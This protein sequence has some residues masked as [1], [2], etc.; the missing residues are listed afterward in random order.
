MIPFLSIIIPVYKVENYLERCVRS[1]L[2]Q[3]YQDYEIILV[4]DGSPDRCPQICDELAKEDNRITVIHKHNGG[5]SSARNAG[6]K[7]ASGDYFAFLDS[8][9]FWETG[10]L[11]YVIQRLKQGYVDM[12][13]YDTI[14]LFPDGIKRKRNNHGFFNQDYIVYDKIDYY[15]KLIEVADFM[16]SA[17]TKVVSRTFL[18]NND[19]LF[20]EGITGEDTEWM[21]RLLRC[22]DKIGVSN[23][24]LFICTYGRTGSIQN[25]IQSKNIIDLLSTIDKSIDFY[26]YNDNKIKKF[27]MEQCA[28]LLSNATGLLRYIKDKNIKTQLIKQLKQRSFLFQY[29]SN[30][31]TLMVKKVYNIFGYNILVLFLETYLYLKRKNILNR[32]KKVDE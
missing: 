14:E 9:D 23:V 24:E 7:A 20:C 22:A 16:E 26:K 10:K 18:Q 11:K 12:I 4:D 17:C 5:L 28:Y 29:A 31:K 6:I 25:S 30:R 15:A 21:I 3:D 2:N 19:L 32:K 8:D 27:E 1:V 13:V